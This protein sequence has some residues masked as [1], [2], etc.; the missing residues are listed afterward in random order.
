MALKV[1]EGD[2]S[3]ALG[4]ASE[5]GWELVSTERT[6]EMYEKYI[7]LFFKKATPVVVDYASKP[8]GKSK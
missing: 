8:K 1:P 6:V 3:T 4:E 2:L 5:D 7:W